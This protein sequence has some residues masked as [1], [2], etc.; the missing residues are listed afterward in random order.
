M[1]RITVQHSNGCCTHVQ[2]RLLKRSGVLALLAL[3]N[4][5]V[6]RREII[7]ADELPLDCLND[8][9]G[10]YLPLLI[11]ALRIMDNRIEEEAESLPPF[12][13]GYGSNPYP[14]PFP[15]SKGARE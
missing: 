2:V 1:K 7:E 9:E 11:Q 10:W 12:L 13:V 4:G 6:V 14:Q 5:V 15:L 8:G 3:K